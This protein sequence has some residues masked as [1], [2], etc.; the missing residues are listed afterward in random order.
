MAELW[1]EVGEL[2]VAVEL[3]VAV[4]RQVEVLEESVPAIEQ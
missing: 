2:Q 1:S 4:E 3:R